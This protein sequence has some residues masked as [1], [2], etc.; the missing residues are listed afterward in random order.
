MEMPDYSDYDGLG[1]AELV[2]NKAVTPLELTEA[3][4]A[5][6]EQHNPTLNA[7]VYK[8]L[9]TPANGRPETCRTA[10]SVASL[11]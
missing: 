7:V 8:A 1:L 3:A 4:I 11:S 6:I 10:R 2:A 5:R 9:T